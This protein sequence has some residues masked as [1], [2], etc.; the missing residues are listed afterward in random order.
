MRFVGS[1][2]IRT[3]VTRRSL[4]AFVRARPPRADGSDKSLRWHDLTDLYTRL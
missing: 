4:R 3:G 2:R 1:N